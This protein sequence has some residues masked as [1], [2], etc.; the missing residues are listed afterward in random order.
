VRRDIR[1]RFEVLVWNPPNVSRVIGDVVVSRVGWSYQRP[2]TGF[3][4]LRDHIA[5]YAGALYRCTVNGE[6][7]T[8]QP[9]KC[10]GGWTTSAL[11]GPF[12][13]GPGSQGW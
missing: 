13:G 2:N 7:V 9:G 12:K 10:Y 5:F 11:A 1:H 3:M 4:L 6:T 8:P